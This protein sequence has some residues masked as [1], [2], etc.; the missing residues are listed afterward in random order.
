MQK[1]DVIVD[2]ALRFDDSI[3][4]ADAAHMLKRAL[5]WQDPDEPESIINLMRRDA[6]RRLVIPRGFALKLRKGLAQYDFEVVWHDN[7]VFLNDQPLTRQLLPNPTPNIETLNY[8]LRAVEQMV[9]TEQGIYEAP[10]GS[11]KTITAAIFLSAVQQPALIMVDKI[12][13]ALQ[14][15]DRL[16]EALGVDLPVGIIGDGVWQEETITVALRQSLWSQRERLD[17][18]RWWERWGVVILDECHAVSAET[19]R[20]LIQRFPAY[21]RI[22]LSAT[23]DR[24]DWLT[25]VSRAIIGEIFTRTEDEELERAG[26]LVRPRIVAVR[27]DF[28]FPWSS[29]KDPKTQWQAMLKDLKF[30]NRRN[31]I[32][33]KVM[34]AQRGHTCLVQ[35][36]HTG[37]ADELAAYALANGW[38]ND[39]VMLLTGQQDGARRMEIRARA[40]QGDCIIFSTIGKEALDIPRLDRYFMPF[41][42]KNATMVKQ[43]IGRV[44]RKHSTKLE[45]PIIYDFWD[46]QM[47]ILA[48]QFNT[49]RGVYD[50]EKI[51]LSV[52]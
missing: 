46:S 52:V 30:N 23:P 36:E 47:R 3:L 51:P 21:F 5:I 35:T 50:R 15:R 10:T 29:H 34:A 39:S 7:R 31:T 49:R 37:Y 48:E 6:Q 4:S 20:E 1:L 24:H 33:G 14:W 2:S 16:H 19:V 44:K 18:M 28:K 17:L 26:R 38:P 27:T 8:Q 41:P 42:A 12:D 40:E 43:M 9:E 13:T 22:G 32:I 25:I 45:P 11:G